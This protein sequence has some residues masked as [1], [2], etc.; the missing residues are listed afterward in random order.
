MITALITKCCIKRIKGK[1]INTELQMA[2]K[3][4][5]IDENQNE[6]SPHVLHGLMVWILP[7]W[8]SV[9][10]QVR[11]QSPYKEADRASEPNLSCLTPKRIRNGTGLRLQ[12]TFR[13]LK[14]A[15]GR[16]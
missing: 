5:S 12:K 6:T 15:S 3:A 11:S 2:Q 1:P 9:H 16:S 14:A 7:C 8:S 13:E 4:E 10:A